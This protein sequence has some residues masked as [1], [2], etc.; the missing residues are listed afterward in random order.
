VWYCVQPGV[1]SEALGG[2]WT[3]GWFLG[4]VFGAGGSREVSGCARRKL[5][6]MHSALNDTGSDR[7]CLTVAACACWKAV[8]V[9]GP[10]VRAPAGS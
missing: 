3:A 9:G 4:R 2:Q 6:R 7:E 5:I 1:G 8:E 10:R